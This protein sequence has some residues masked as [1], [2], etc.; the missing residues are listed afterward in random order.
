MRATLPEM[1]SQIKLCNMADLSSK[2]SCLASATISLRA[3]PLNMFRLGLTTNI[4]SKTPIFMHPPL[5][6]FSGIPSEINTVEKLL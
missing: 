2:I 5:V 6:K 4:Q 1:V 3:Q